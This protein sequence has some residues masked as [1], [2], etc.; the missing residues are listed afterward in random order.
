[1]HHR[2]PYMV[3]NLQQNR[4]NR[5]VMTMRISLFAKIA[6]CINLQLPIIIFKTSV[7]SDMRHRKTY[8]Y[9]NFQQNLGSR[10]SKPCTQI[11]LQRIA[12]Y[13]NLQLAIRI[14]KNLAF[15]TCTTP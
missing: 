3:I 2:K 12:N 10:M 9:V 13:I 15:L 1:M 8:M 11:Y 5:S 4:V 14:S 6:S 7:V